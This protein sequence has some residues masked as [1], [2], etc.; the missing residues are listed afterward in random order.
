M[1]NLECQDIENF[2]STSSIVDNFIPD[3]PLKS[4]VDRLQEKSNQQNWEQGDGVIRNSL[5]HDTREKF[6]NADV[7]YCPAKDI[8][9]FM[10]LPFFCL[11]KRNDHEFSFISN[12]DGRN[13]KL[14]PGKYGLAKQLDKDILLYLV[15]Q[16]I[17]KINAKQR[18]SRVVRINPGKF[19]KF[20]GQQNGGDSYRRL[21][22]GIVRLLEMQ[23]STD[24]SFKHDSSIGFTE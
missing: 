22:E 24:I 23:I 20:S 19:L 18:V 6:I 12:N 11:S 3:N 16:I 9:K 8:V 17:A 2:V 7:D 10:E 4:K 14:F 21:R 15:S 5:I 13:I 1:K